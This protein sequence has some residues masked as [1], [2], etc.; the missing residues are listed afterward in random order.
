LDLRNDNGLV[1]DGALRAQIDRVIASLEQAADTLIGLRRENF[2]TL[3]TTLETVDSE[4][5]TLLALIRRQCAG[6][7]RPDSSTRAAANRLAEMNVRV[8]RL[9]NAARDFHTNLLQIRQTEEFGYQDPAGRRT[10][11]AAAAAPHSLEI[12]V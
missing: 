1:G 5:R 3:G 4:Q 6:S 11:S 8:R 10:A 2:A 7:L 9:Y 12:R